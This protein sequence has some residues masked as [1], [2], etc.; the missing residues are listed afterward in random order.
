MMQVA[1]SVESQRCV[2]FSCREGTQ[3]PKFQARLLPTFDFALPAQKGVVV[4]CVGCVWLRVRWGV[5]QGGHR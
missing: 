2:F 3:W 1:G 4:L 5:G